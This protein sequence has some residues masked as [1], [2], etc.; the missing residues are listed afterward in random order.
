M[1]AFERAQQAVRHLRRLQIHVAVDAADHE[2]QLAQR[3]VCQIHRAVAADVAFEA[4]EHANAQTALVPSREPVARTRPR[5]L[6]SSP[7]AI[8]S[9]F[10]WSVMAMYS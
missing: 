9:A 2:I 7:F 5:A 3:V 4:G 10:E 6:S 8:A 1:R